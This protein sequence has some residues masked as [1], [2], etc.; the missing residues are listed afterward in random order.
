MPE[1]AAAATASSASGQVLKLEWAEG[2]PGVGNKMVFPLFMVQF[3]NI[4]KASFLNVTA[5]ASLVAPFPLNR[6]TLAF[7]LQLVTPLLAIDL[8]VLR[9]SSSFSCEYKFCVVGTSHFS[10][11]LYK[12]F[13]VKGRRKTTKNEDLKIRIIIN[14]FHMLRSIF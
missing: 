1:R 6:Q 7:A 4:P 11:G 10:R 2:S 13:K 8:S 5:A 14:I 3:L 9:L 12:G